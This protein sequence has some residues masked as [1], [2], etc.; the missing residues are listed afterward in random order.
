MFENA[1]RAFLAC[2]VLSLGQAAASA[3]DNVLILLADDLGV[4][5]LACY[6]VG[7]DLPL[8]PNIDRLAAEGVRFENCWSNPLCS[9]TR[10]TLQTGRY[11]SGSGLGHLVEDGTQALQPEELTL[12]EVL[13]DASTGYAH[14]AFGKWHLGN[15]D[16]G[17]ALAP[18]LAGWSHFSGT[19]GNV[20]N[21]TKWLKVENGQYSISKRYLTSDT[22]NEALAWIRTQTQPWVAY[23][24]F[25]TP[26]KPFHAPPSHL[27]TQDL[28]S[29]FPPSQTENVRP[30]WKAMVES[31][32]TEIGRLLTGIGP[33]L[34]STTVI[35]LGDNG[36]S[37]YVVVPP[38]ESYKAKGS[39]YQGGVHV[40]LIV[41]GSQ[42]LSEGSTS[43]ALVNT[44]DVY[45]T[46]LDI[47]GVPAD[48]LS[49]TPNP[50]VP[51]LTEFGDFSMS[52]AAPF[53][54]EGLETDSISFLPF[55]RNPAQR[56]R[57]EYA[58]AEIFLPNGPGP[59]DVDCRAVR[60]RRFK[61]MVCEGVNDPNYDGTFFFDL[62]DD[63][64]ERK[65]LLDSDLEDDALEA[66]WRLNVV[67]AHA[68]T[69][70]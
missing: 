14:A 4:D 41:W 8:T 69:N 25:N 27:H 43:D 26:H 47:A 10:A 1:K 3:Q 30:W 21:Y 39:V 52:A 24:A 42:V 53:A 19:L 67:L 61:L 2:A 35:F 57:R 13:D 15:E 64:L 22:V 66:Y 58:L 6:G 32:D 49:P 12:P 31:M 48:E 68:T 36:T 5:S 17:G 23:V 9:P 34:Q 46:V 37:R 62:K 38:F 70:D 11:A 50:Q 33:A 44:T 60:D 56:S 51:M 29:Q 16:V 18:N 63:P 65:N 40:P 54:P 28:P 20:P 45:A 59:Y 7:S 55:I